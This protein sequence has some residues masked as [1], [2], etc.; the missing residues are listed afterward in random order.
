MATFSVWARE[1]S[2]TAGNQSLNPIGTNHAPATQ[3]TFTD[4][5]TGDLSLDASNGLPDPDTQVIINNVA[6]NFTVRLTGTLPAG[7]SQ[8]P[9]GLVGRSVVLLE[10]VINGKAH[11]YFY[12]L[13]EPPA[14][15]AEMNA[16]GNGAI[17]LSGVNLD[18]P[19]ICFCAGTLID[20][21]SGRRAVETLRP[22]ETVLT[23]DGRAVPLAWIG[24]SSYSAAALAADPALRPVR[25][26]AHAFAP[27][28]PERDLDLSPQHRVVLEDPACD[29]FFGAPRVFVTAR[30]LLGTLAHVPQEGE[31]VCY[32]HLLLERHEIL[33]AEGLPAE[34][35]QPARRMVGLMA[36]PVRNSL[37]QTLEALGAE[38]I[39]A[40]PDALPTLK[41][42]EAAVL[43]RQLSREA[44]HCPASASDYGLTGP[45]RN[46][47]RP[48]T[49]VRSTE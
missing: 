18:P 16:F 32:V 30:H 43:M 41:S 1:D 34:S 24:F 15:Q 6:Y 37:L 47:T 49:A 8:V 14:T 4:N 44:P 25:I 42:S 40:R 20:T 21:P 13:G 31:G 38:A 28:L 7:N 26:P 23:E 33:L 2:T 22:G 29:L 17:P 12:V 10:V 39:L 3:L 19:P 45:G 11:E 27:G 35:F 9:G 36:G 46:N 48:S 5:G